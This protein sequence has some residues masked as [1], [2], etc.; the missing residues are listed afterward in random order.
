MRYER[1]FIKEAPKKIRL[2]NGN[3]IHDVLLER[4]RQIKAGDQ[5]N[6]NKSSVQP[7]RKQGVG[8]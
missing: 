3:I 1:T 5:L 2:P 7:I 4:S 8:G 6:R